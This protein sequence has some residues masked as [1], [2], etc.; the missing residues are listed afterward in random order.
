MWQKFGDGLQGSG[1]HQEISIPQLQGTR[2]AIFPPFLTP[3]FKTIQH[4][5]GMDHVHH[6][7][8]Y[9]ALGS[10]ASGTSQRPVSRDKHRASGSSLR[11]SVSDT[12]STPGAATSGSCSESEA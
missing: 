11:S 6:N 1:L 9:Y 5:R 4:V 12:A 7:H 3:E 8:T 10:E 2:E